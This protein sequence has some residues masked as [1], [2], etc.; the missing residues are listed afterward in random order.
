MLKNEYLVQ[1]NNND[2]VKLKP[3][4][5]KDISVALEEKLSTD[6]L[7]MYY[8]LV[9]NYITLYPAP[10]SGDVTLA[11]GMAIRVSRDVTEFPTTASTGTPGFAT[12]F[13]RLLSISA[14]LDFE[15]D[16]DQR[17]LLLEMKARLEKGIQRFYGKREV[18]GHTAITPFGRKRQ[19]QYE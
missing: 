2:W 14:S 10:A 17:N 16:R 8:D 13:H 18:E 19:R 15:K 3:L 11:S 7:P 4:D 1:D 6:G 9:G 5:Y 12:Q